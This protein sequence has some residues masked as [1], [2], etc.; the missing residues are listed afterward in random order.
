[1]TLIALISIV[2]ICII[3]NYFA[4]PYHKEDLENAA[5]NV[6]SEQAEIVDSAD[7]SGLVFYVA[8][9]DNASKLIAFQKNLIL[10]KFKISRTID[11]NEVEGY[12]VFSDGFY[13]YL[14]KFSHEQ[15][16]IYSKERCL[17]GGYV[18][19]LVIIVVMIVGFFLIRRVGN[20]GV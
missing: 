20:R 10:P 8:K 18:G 17:W 4:Y 11:T 16:E 14:M 7:G 9:S 5:R 3:Y 19:N 12:T 13:N 6:V 15:V 1:V 2:I